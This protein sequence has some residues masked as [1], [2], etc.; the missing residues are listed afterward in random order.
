MRIPRPF[1]LLFVGLTLAGC[2]ST[3]GFDADRRVYAEPLPFVLEAVNEALAEA[4]FGIDDSR[5]GDDGTII[6][7]GF[8]Q[9][10]AFGQTTRTRSFT[11]FVSAE[12]PSGTA[13]RFEIPDRQLSG[14]AYS[15]DREINV[16]RLVFNRLEERLT[17]TQ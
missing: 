12:E 16:S 8:E 11:V 9:S 6:I 17:E 5:E 10:R 3:A 7:E 13:V 1:V 4:G 15:A 2:A 14:A